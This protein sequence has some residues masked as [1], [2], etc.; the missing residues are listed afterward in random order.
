MFYSVVS[1]RPP[2][3][4]SNP[5]KR[6]KTSSI[7]SPRQFFVGHLLNHRGSL[8]GRS[9]EEAILPQWERCVEYFDLLCNLLH[10][11]KCEYALPVLFSC[12]STFTK[13]SFSVRARIVWYQC[14]D[15]VEGGVSLVRGGEGSSQPMSEF[16]DTAGWSSSALQDTVHL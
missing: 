8:W 5:V 13:L 12:V 1:S 16:P 2:L 11:A 4:D 9:L 15:Y 14:C 3:S 10:E 7:E 6:L